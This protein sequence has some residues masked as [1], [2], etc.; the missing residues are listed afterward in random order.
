VGIFENE[1]DYDDIAYGDIPDSIQIEEASMWAVPEDGTY[2]PAKAVS[3]V[4]PPGVYEIFENLGNVFFKSVS[5]NKE[6][7]I[8]VEGSAC[9]HVTSDVNNFWGRRHLFEQHGFNHKRGILLWGPPGSGK[10]SICRLVMQD[11][12][13]QGGVVFRFRH[14]TTF[15]MGMSAFRLI[16]PDTPV[17][18]LMEDVES[19]LNSFS[20]SEIL[21]ILDGVHDIQHVI[22]L[23]T[24]NYPEMLGERIRNRP[25]RFDRRIHVGYPSEEARLSYLQYLFS[26]VDSP[27]DLSAWASSTPGFTFAHL[28]ELF[29]SV[30]LFGNEYETALSELKSMFEPISSGDEDDI[31]ASVFGELNTDSEGAVPLELTDLE[32]EKTAV[33]GLGALKDG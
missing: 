26:K 33:F 25:S 8:R 10:S 32:P 29:I 24:T 18:V 1:V 16:Q 22:Y 13:Q 19:I 23:A 17:V 3:R 31:I 2:V 9:D 6:P 30:V 11:V 4:L 12:I 7:L 27:P 15:V 14:P 28:K 20:E 21:N 5:M